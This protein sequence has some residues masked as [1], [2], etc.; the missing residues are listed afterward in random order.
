MTIQC[1]ARVVSDEAAWF[2]CVV[3]R[4]A[5][6]FD[7]TAPPVD[8]TIVR[9]PIECMPTKGLQLREVRASSPDDPHGPTSR[10]PAI[11]LPDGPKDELV[12]PHSTLNAFAS[13]SVARRSISWSSAIAR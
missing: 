8:L 5:T 4:P 1:T 11:A 10:Y 2:R 7:P 3:R 6:V 9:A 13:F 12:L